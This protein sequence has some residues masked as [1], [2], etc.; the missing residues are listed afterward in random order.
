MLA[1]GTSRNDHIM[2]ALP[3]L[4][5][6]LTARTL[7]ILMRFPWEAAGERSWRLL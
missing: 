2:A 4:L 7:D 3:L 1:A 6:K 5:H